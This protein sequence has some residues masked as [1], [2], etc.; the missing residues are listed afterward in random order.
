M[1]Q[2]FCDMNALNSRENLQ[3]RTILQRPP[4]VPRFS[5][6]TTQAK[7]RRKG[8]AIVQQRSLYERS[9]E[10]RILLQ[11]CMGVANRLPRP[12]ARRV[13]VQ[14][15]SIRSAYEKVTNE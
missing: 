6:S 13:L 15:A 2:R 11:Q 10:T 3:T 9:L 7:D 14:E 5:S 1:R 4:L 12:A 8:K